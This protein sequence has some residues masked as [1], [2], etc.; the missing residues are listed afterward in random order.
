MYV[1]FACKDMLQL[2][3]LFKISLL[4][5]YRDLKKLNK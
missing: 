2:S 3:V 1:E 4:T 5:L